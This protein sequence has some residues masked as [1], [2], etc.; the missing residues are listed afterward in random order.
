[1]KE[2]NHLKERLSQGRITRRDFIR[3][4]I[5][6]GVAL[7][8]ATSL[9]STVLAATPN[10]GG[11]LRQAL[12]GAASSDSLDP[13]TYLD[14]YMINVGMGQLRNNLTEIDE[15]NQLVPELA[16]SWDSSDGQTWMFNIRKGV[17][18]HNGRSLKAND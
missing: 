9:S 3:S 8:T 15:N 10:K 11:M 14:S 6:L 7:P 2:I 13:A 1:M 4:A 5:A 16:E 17:E 12:T 18:F